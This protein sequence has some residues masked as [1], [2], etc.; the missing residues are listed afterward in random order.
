MTEPKTYA[1]YLWRERTE[2]GGEVDKTTIDQ[3]S[4]DT[5]QTEER[6]FSDLENE[7]DLAYREIEVLRKGVNVLLDAGLAATGAF[8]E[9]AAQPCSKCGEQQ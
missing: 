2:S 1:E 6:K 7:L 9:L 3:I 5:E 4:C 8:K